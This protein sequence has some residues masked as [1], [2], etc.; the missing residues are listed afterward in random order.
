MPV[1]LIDKNSIF[2]FVGNDFIYYTEFKRFIFTMSSIDTCN[3]L[4]L[5]ARSGIEIIPATV[6]LL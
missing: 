4:P 2:P 5:L 3:M 1:L 6:I